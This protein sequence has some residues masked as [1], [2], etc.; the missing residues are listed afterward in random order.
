MRRLA[1]FLLFSVSISANSQTMADQEDLNEQSVPLQRQAIINKD[2]PNGNAVFCFGQDGKGLVWIGAEDGL[3]CFDGYNF[4]PH[5]RLGGQLNTRINSI[6]SLGDILYLCTDDGLFAYDVSTDIY[7]KVEGSPKNVNISV[8]GK[9]WNKSA[10]SGN[11]IF[12]GS[13]KGVMVLDVKSGKLEKLEGIDSNVRVFTILGD[14]LLVGVSDTL[15]VADLPSMTIKRRLSLGNNCQI[16]SIEKDPKDDFVWIGTTGGLFSI[17]RNSGIPI[18]VEP[19]NGL[20]IRAL[21]VASSGEVVIGTGNGLYTYSPE[22]P[23]GLG[24][25]KKSEAKRYAH[26][27]RNPQSIRNNSIE[28]LFEDKWHNLWIGTANGVS[29]VVIPSYMAY[30]PISDITDNGLGNCIKSVLLDSSGECWLGGSDGLIHQP[31][32]LSA[33]KAPKADV[34]YKKE[35][36]KN[37]LNSDN[38]NCVYEDED[39]DIWIATNGGVGFLDRK[40]RQFRNFIITNPD[41]N[42][43]SRRACS[44]VMDRLRRLWVSAFSDGIFV[45]EKDKL[46]ASGGQFPTATHI[47]TAKEGK[48]GLKARQLVLDKKGNIYAAIEGKGIYYIEYRLLGIAQIDSTKSINS[49]TVDGA[50]NLWMAYNGGMCKYN[51]EEKSRNFMEISRNGQPANMLSVLIVGEEIWALTGDELH[52]MDSEMRE[53]MVV[54]LPISNTRTAYFSSLTGNMVI[55]A[56]DALII[57]S[58]TRLKMGYRQT[59]ILLTDLRI[60]GKSIQTD[61][62][63]ASYCQTADGLSLRQT[64]GIKLS[65]RNCAISL[66]LSC[67][68]YSDS[69][70]IKF[71][72]KLDGL[73]HS[74]REID[75]ETCSITF[76]GL[77]G[78]KHRLAI[79]VPGSEGYDEIYNLDIIVSQPWYKSLWAIILY[80]ILAILFIGMLI[81]LLRMGLRL[82]KERSILEEDKRL[83]AKKM[84][85]VNSISR[86][87]EDSLISGERSG[88]NTDLIPEGSL[89]DSKLLEEIIRIVDKKMYDSNFN[90]TALQDMLGIGSKM[91]Y[92]KVKRLTGSSPAEFIRKTRLRRAAS[93][94]KQGQFTVSEVVYMV[95]FTS[96]SYFA[97]SFQKEYGVNPSEYARQTED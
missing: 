69:P 10:N 85:S 3:Y 26:D 7:N 48:H 24:N 62:V 86:K 81:F 50:D 46:L 70:A 11:L 93:L 35:N 56:D 88:I 16:S 31:E 75:A 15:V 25:Y 20:R 28:S 77:S 74:F 66:H 79:F 43:T 38:I 13:E 5:F 6:S 42:Y 82:K 47:N 60:D 61:S 95:G 63:A 9:N 22:R 73:G 68:P 57:I 1:I 33:S 72:Y 45:V 87:L 58:P 67:I 49:M 2:M 51:S 8:V 94:L 44:I 18:A 59:G 19:L 14:E 91:M 32:G 83:S 34:W 30:I 64:K 21:K 96:A 71:F 36:G 84:E 90:A 52:V 92:R 89:S 65:R 23:S 80:V 97:K 39:G 37:P 40:T 53:T 78:G 55:G 41:G 29:L 17:S 12:I 27:S 4:V 54:R 76:S